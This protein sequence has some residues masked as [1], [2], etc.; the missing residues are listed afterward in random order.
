MSTNEYFNKAEHKLYVEPNQ[1]EKINI[2]A[3]INRIM[4]ILYNAKINYVTAGELDV[5]RKLEQNGFNNSD[6]YMDCHN[7]KY[8]NKCIVLYQTETFDSFIQRV[9]KQQGGKLRKGYMEKYIKYSS[10]NVL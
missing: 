6:I 3:Y 2:N 1:N 7:V 9:R 5:K 10:K 4:N 8:L